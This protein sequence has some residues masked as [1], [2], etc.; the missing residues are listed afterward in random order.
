Q[1]DHTLSNLLFSTTEAGFDE[2]S[3]LFVWKVQ[4]NPFISEEEISVF[5]PDIVT[6]SEEGS[7]IYVPINL[8]TNPK[9][10]ESLADFKKAVEVFNTVNGKRV[11]RAM[12]AALLLF[13]DQNICGG[14][15]IIQVSNTGQEIVYN[16]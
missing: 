6:H 1:R 15:L 12:D 11:R 3:G 14:S 13:K 7:G 9:N 16:Y 10:A 2:S 5:N 4:F 8:R